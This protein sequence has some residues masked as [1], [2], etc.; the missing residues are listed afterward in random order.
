MPTN[1]C[2]R[3]FRA[4]LRPLQNIGFSSR[5]EIER[6]TRLLG[7]YYEVG[8]SVPFFDYMMGD[9]PYG[10]FET[11]VNAILRFAN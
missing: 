5:H 4:T 2:A 1:C 9:D 6:I 11:R 3:H 8:G 7:A 10:C